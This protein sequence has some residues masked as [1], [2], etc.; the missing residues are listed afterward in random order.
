MAE[1]LSFD[2]PAKP[3]LGRDD[4]FVSPA[5]ALAVAMIDSPQTWPGGKLV[6]TGPGGAGKTHLTHVWA[7]QTGAQILAAVDLSRQEIPLLAQ[8]PVAVEDVPDIASDAPAQNA[9]FHLHNLLM[10]QG[11]RLLMTGRLA[12]NLWNLSLPDLQSRVQGAAHITLD[13]PDDKLLA[14]VL[15]KLFADRQITPKPD[16]I[17]YLLHRMDRSFLDA[18]RIVERL[19]RA[20][21]AQGRTL[22]RRLASESLEADDTND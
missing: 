2:L 18:T 21:L 1:Q 6:L 12:P 11:Q 8:G 9:L 22:S 17:P 3:V 16:V 10:A 4:F 7:A 19:D 5:N 13:A 20:A 15:A 14:A